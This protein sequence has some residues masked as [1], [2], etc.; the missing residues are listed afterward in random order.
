MGLKDLE[1][2]GFD[3]DDGNK[4]KCRKHGVGLEEIEELF[5]Y[6]VTLFPDLDHSDV[7]ERFKAIGKTGK[8][9]YIL[10]VFTIRQREEKYFIRPIS[11][12]YMHHKEVEYYEKEIA[13]SEE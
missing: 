7:E 4:E 12:R 5:G 1:L 8:G 3:W 9:R 6:E 13:D 2:S 10:L 11:A